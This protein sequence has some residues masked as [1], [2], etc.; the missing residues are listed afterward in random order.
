MAMKG[1]PKA[2][3]IVETE[4]VNSFLFGCEFP[5][6]LRGRERRRERVRLS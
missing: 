2:L 3:R 4:M 1:N 5:Y 6:E